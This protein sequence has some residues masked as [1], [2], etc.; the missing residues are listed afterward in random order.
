MI[1]CPR[2][3]E[4]REL[5][6]FHKGNRH[7]HQWE[8]K[9]CSRIQ[10]KKEYQAVI[11]NPT[12]R[13]KALFVGMLHNRRRRLETLRIVGRGKI[14]CCKCGC[15]NIALLTINHING[16]GTRE[17]VMKGNHLQ[18]DVRCGRRPIDDLNL[19]CAP[20]NWLDH[21]ERKFGQTGHAITWC[22]PT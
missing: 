8:C 18:E 16:G 9:I 2:C 3:K 10:A 6:D 19:L 21:Y 20:C 22:R 11:N 14:E 5:S 15:D 1:I 13:E 7:G 4:V 17:R 12:R